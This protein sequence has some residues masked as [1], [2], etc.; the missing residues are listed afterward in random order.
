[1]ISAAGESPAH[2]RKAAKHHQQ[3]PQIE[4]ALSGTVF[5][6]RNIAQKLKL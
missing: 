5:A 4:R 2:S 3:F 1:M 6:P